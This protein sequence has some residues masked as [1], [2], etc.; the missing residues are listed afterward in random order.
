MHVTDMSACSDNGRL[1]SSFTILLQNSAEELQN[2]LVATINA[3]GQLDSTGGLR[4]HPGSVLTL[5]P[6]A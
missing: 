6:L 4:K 5:V 3:M 2:S 1:Q